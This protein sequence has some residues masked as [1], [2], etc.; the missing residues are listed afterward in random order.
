M[1]PQ[2]GWA[3]PDADVHR[4]GRSQVRREALDLERRVR[5]LDEAVDR[6]GDQAG[7]AQH[8]GA[9]LL[10][11]EGHVAEVECRGGDR[12]D[13]AERA[14]LGLAR[15]PACRQHQHARRR[16]ELPHTAPPRTRH[17]AVLYTARA[18]V[19]AGERALV[20]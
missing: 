5:E 12:E 7:V 4:A 14:K 16:P 11:A 17:R 10:L 15:A 2:L 1:R 8:D 13:P 6:H 18:K 20:G 3:V 19:R 9:R